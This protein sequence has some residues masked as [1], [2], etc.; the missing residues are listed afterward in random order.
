MSKTGRSSRVKTIIPLERFG[1]VGQGGFGEP[2]APLRA[3][4]R[5][6]SGEADAAGHARRRWRVAGGGWR[7]PR[8]SP[9]A[10][11]DPAMMLYSR[12]TEDW[13]WYKSQAAES[14]SYLYLSVSVDGGS[15]TIHFIHD[16]EHNSLYRPSN[17]EASLS[18]KLKF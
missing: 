1:D 4:L 12:A 7:V 11:F 13:L 10:T 2:P 16:A 18:L 3:L 8:R 17:S 15:H 14:C 5:L 6:A 9:W